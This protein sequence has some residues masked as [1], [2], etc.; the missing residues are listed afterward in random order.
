MYI[1]IGRT[2]NYAWSLTSASHDVRDVFAERLC[3]PD[4][5]APTRASTH[6]LYKGQCR[7]F[8]DFNA[9]TLNGT[10]L[11]YRISVHGRSSDRHRRRQAVRAVAQALDVRPRRPQ[12]GRAEGH[13]RGQ[14]DHPAAV[15]P[16]PTSSASRST[17]PTSS[18]KATAYFSSGH[19]P[20]RRG[21]STAACRRS[22]PALRVAGFLRQDEHPHDVG[23]PGGLL[24]NWNNQ[25]APGFM[26]GDDEP[27]GS[28]TASSCSTEWP[29]TPWLTDVV[30][31]MNRAA[32]E[33]VRSPVW[34]V[35]SRGAAAARRRAPATQ[36]VVDLLDDWVRRDAPRLD[37]DNDGLYDEP[38]RR[39]WTRSGG[40][41][42][43]R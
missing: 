7:A 39:S 35:V 26:H 3:E 17:G 19:L 8:E 16:P 21:A 2:K 36:Q 12:P 24:L 15:L 11:R 22:A 31:V 34:P 37:A 9:G 18:R 23:G 5:S 14:G 40:R 32:T 33:D 28:V 29:G 41:S 42:P 27:Y 25:S 30:G 10:P 43:R 6:Y 38:A 4:G 1:L 20:R 13:D